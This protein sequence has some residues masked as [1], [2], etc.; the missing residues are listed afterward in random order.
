[1]DKSISSN[2]TL[3][4]ESL[5]PTSTISGLDLSNI[6]PIAVLS[7]H[8]TDDEDK[9]LRE[10][11]R[12]YDAPLTTDVARAKVFIG[13]VGTKRRAEF[14]LRS[15]KIAVEVI[16]PSKRPAS[17]IN[18]EEPTE[19]RRKPLEGTLKPT[20]ARQCDMIAGEEGVEDTETEDEASQEGPRTSLFSSSMTEP[21]RRTISIF[22]DTSGKDFVWV[23]KVDWLEAC[24]TAGASE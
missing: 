8:L 7:A 10:T 15:R 18:A 14:E 20:S 11:L 23:V 16:T 1:M 3:R 4:T 9:L 6:P 22:D 12:Q 2:Q 13:K 19:K 24:V 21:Q 17:P 5:S